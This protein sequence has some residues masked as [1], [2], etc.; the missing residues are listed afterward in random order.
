[1]TFRPNYADCSV[2]RVFYLAFQLT[3][4]CLLAT[5]TGSCITGT[6]PDNFNC[7][8]D[9]MWT[10][11]PG[12]IRF[13]AAEHI[14]FSQCEFRHMG[15]KHAKRVSDS[16]SSSTTFLVFTSAI[17]LVSCFQSTRPPLRSFYHLASA[18]T[19]M[20]RNSEE[21]K[22]KKEKRV[23]IQALRDGHENCVCGRGSYTENRARFCNTYVT[24]V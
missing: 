23:F 20:R 11:S 22:E 9:Y 8:D 6:N 15:G 3:P 19:A 16:R 18:Q 17:P 1:M 5:F 4:F 10:K 14:T 24:M 12:N 21:K 7:D 2:C 13:A